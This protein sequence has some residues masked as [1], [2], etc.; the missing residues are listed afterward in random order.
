M[1]EL[2]RIRKVF[3]VWQEYL[4]EKWLTEMAAQGLHLRKVGF[5]V[6]DFEKGKPKDVTYRLYSHVG[7]GKDTKACNQL[8]ED[9]GWEWM[10]SILSWQYFRK[11]HE[12]GKSDEI[13]SDNQSKWEALKY[14]RNFSLGIGLLN[15]YNFLNI[16]VLSPGLASWRSFGM[17]LMR[18]LVLAVSGLLLYGTVKI[19]KRMNE[20]KDSML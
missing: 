2:I 8:F 20:L 5:C 15:L 4:E 10:G 11:P 17:D 12:E 9:M 3:F 1:S 6:Y 13:L 19:Q 14:W 18:L 16:S 7:F